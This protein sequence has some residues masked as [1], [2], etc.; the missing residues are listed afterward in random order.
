MKRLYW[1]KVQICGRSPRRSEC[2]HMHLHHLTRCVRKGQKP[3]PCSYFHSY[4]LW[5]PGTWTEFEPN[6]DLHLRGRATARSLGRDRFPFQDRFPVCVGC[7]LAGESQVWIT[8][9]IK[10][11]PTLL[12][13]SSSLL[14]QHTPPALSVGQVFY[15]PCFNTLSDVSD[16]QTGPPL[17]LYQS[18]CCPDLG[19]STA[20]S[21]W[22]HGRR[23]DPI[24]CR[25]SWADSFPQISGLGAEQGWRLSLLVLVSKPLE[26]T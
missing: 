6:L 23:Y 19:C 14:S 8:E 1:L 24:N 17:F 16:S 10:G 4:M 25:A 15:W 12:S 7:Y 13:H 9:T 3:A 11:L 21:G 18:P 22:E 20:R 2:M 5:Q 26:T